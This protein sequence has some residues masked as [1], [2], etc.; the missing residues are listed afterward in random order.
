MN[1]FV[2]VEF[3][4]DTAHTTRA[5]VEMAALGNDFTQINSGMDWRDNDNGQYLGYYRISGKINSAT[6]TAI[7]LSNKFLAD[8]MRISYIP[9]E[10]KDKYRR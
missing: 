5:E 1:E 8:S 3:M 10:L 7:K 2:F 4:F 9:A 6:A